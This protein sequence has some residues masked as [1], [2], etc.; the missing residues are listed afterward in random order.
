MFCAKEALAEGGAQPEEIA[1]MGITYQRETT[2]LWDRKPGSPL[3]CHRVAVP[4]DVR[5]VRCPEGGRPPSPRARAHGLVV[6]AYFSATKIKW[7]IENVPGVK[8]KVAGGDVCMGTV[9]LVI[10]NLTAV[11]SHVTDYSNAARTM[12]LNTHTLQWT[13]AA[14]RIR[15][16]PVDPP[17]TK[18][19]LRSAG[20]DLTRGLLRPSGADCGAGETRAPRLSGRPVSRREWRKTPMA[21]RSR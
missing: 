12:L 3:Q 9:D 7:I 11:A 13:G 20:R 15:R 5:D 4:P 21:P 18:A 14:R 17:R 16:P 10:W 6:D 1:A 19:V 8:E 2:I